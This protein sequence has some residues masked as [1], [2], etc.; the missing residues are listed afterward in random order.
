LWGVG[1]I[2]PKARARR[3]SHPP[4]RKKKKRKKKKKSGK[5]GKKDG[6]QNNSNLDE[7]SKIFKK[8]R[9]IQKVENRV[10]S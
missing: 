1:K 3:L 10:I 6:I 9:E 4:G 5:I 2:D 7:N 8:W